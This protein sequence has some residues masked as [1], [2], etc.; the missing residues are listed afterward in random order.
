MFDQFKTGR[1]PRTPCK[2]ALRPLDLLSFARQIAMGMVRL[3]FYFSLI[4]DQAF[5]IVNA[6]TLQIKFTVDFVLIKYYI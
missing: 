2:D 3:N 1:A 6:F 4:L 5:A